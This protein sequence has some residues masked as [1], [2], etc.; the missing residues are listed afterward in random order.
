MQS[1]SLNVEPSPVITPQKPQAK[2]FL[3]GPLLAALVLFLAISPWYYGLVRFRDQLIAEC[4][5]FSLFIASFSF[6]KWNNVFRPA[7]HEMDFWVFWVGALSLG[8]TLISS[9]PYLSLLAFSKLLSLLL[10]YGLIRSVVNTTKRLET[11]L[12]AIVFIGFIY[13]AYGLAQ[14]FDFF[15][16]A[17]WSMPYSLASRFVNGSHFAVFLLFPLLMG[18]SLF[19]S[20]KSLPLKSLLSLFLAV[21][22]CAIV[23]SRSRAAW[24]LIL[25]GPAI[26]FWQTAYS[27][28]IKPV[29]LRLFLLPVILGG[30]FLLYKTG[31]IGLILSRIEDMGRNKF[32]S[33]IHRFDL[34]KG[35]LLAI[36]DRPWGWG[37][38]TFMWVF[39]PFKVQSDRFLVDYAHNEFLQI[40]V[41]LGIPGMLILAAFLFFYLKRVI[42]F[43]PLEG[44]PE[45]HPLIASG[46]ASLFICLAIASQIDFPLRIFTNGLFFF[47]FL[48]LSA[49]LFKSR[50]PQKASS[51]SGSAFKWLLFISA[52]SLIVVSSRQ[53]LAE[54]SFQKAQVDDQNFRWNDALENYERAVG[55]AP[56]YGRY[57]EALGNLCYRKASVTF[58]KTEKLKLR[59]KSVQAYERAVQTLPYDAEVHRVLGLA[60]E[61]QGNIDEAKAHLKQA[62][63]LDPQNGF[64]L[65]EYGNFAVRQSWVTEAQISFKK[66]L[67]LIYWGEA[68]DNFCSIIRKFYELTRD[69]QEVLSIMPD[70]DRSHLCLAY[71]LE[72]AGK[73]DEAKTE[74]ERAIV[75]IELYSPEDAKP[76]RKHLRGLD[77]AH[78]PVKNEPNSIAS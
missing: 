30:A 61:E 46:F 65:S 4:F 57:Q 6:V 58:Q 63:R 48:A 47:T 71:I 32:F 56:G 53:L 55:L 3:E 70:D 23:L 68:S 29:N 10:W 51:R 7:V 74:F 67:R 14:Y 35:S 15:P 42:K 33:L 64:F 41:D 21:I 11:F 77:E 62:V 5:I 16:H 26:F 19:F 66:L 78:Q 60:L 40:G 27:K 2:G 52:L 28:T 36:Q 22:V 25:I 44:A 39:P 45:N 73:W 34:W 24:G 75:L 76:I 8:Y 9:L 37:L 72:E 50:S 13:S 31:G 54:I 59:Q 69:Y 17:Y 1:V 18:M 12:W 38:G 49:H 20:V 43:K